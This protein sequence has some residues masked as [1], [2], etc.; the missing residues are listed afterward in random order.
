M[1]I[2][3]AIVWLWLGAYF[4][5][6][7]GYACLGNLMAHTA[8]FVSFPTPWWWAWPHSFAALICINRSMTLLWTK[9]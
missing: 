2:A 3:K 9:P 5:L 8:P 4:V 7:G 1:K 6:V